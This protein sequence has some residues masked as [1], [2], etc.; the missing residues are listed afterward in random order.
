VRQ[1]QLLSSVVKVLDALGIDYM[2]TGAVASSLQG[3]PR[4]VHDIDILVRLNEEDP[5]RLLEAFPPPEF[6]LNEAS[7]R[8]AI[9]AG[10]SFSLIHPQSGVKVDFWIL[11]DDGL[12]R[13]R[14]ARKQT[15]IFH[16]LQFN[17]SA[18]E[19]TILIKLKWAKVMGGK[20]KLFN[21]ALHIYEL[22]FEKL[23]LN[24][25]KHWAREL[26]IDDLFTQLQ[27]KATLL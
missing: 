9:S 2:V 19:D 13:S 27:D 8:D 4:A 7:M 24:Y 18:P 16:G 15:V 23:D 5:E 6:H 11:T 12:D 20:G 22:Q 26:G 25:L 1:Q 17:V 10:G 14:L 21:D 3:S